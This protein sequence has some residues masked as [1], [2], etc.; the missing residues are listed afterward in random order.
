MKRLG[1]ETWK[2]IFRNIRENGEEVE[3]LCMDD[4]REWVLCCDCELFED[5]FKT[6]Q[7]ARERL[8][9]LESATTV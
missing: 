7:E 5:G 6:E 4:T 1:I 9:Y 3:I 2:D 8:E